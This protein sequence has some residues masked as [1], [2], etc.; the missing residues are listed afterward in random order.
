MPVESGPS[1]EEEI[2]DQDVEAEGDPEAEDDSE[3]IDTSKPCVTG[4]AQQRNGSVKQRLGLL[5]ASVVP[6]VMIYLMLST[7]ADR[8]WSGPTR[9]ELP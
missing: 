8:V 3:L 4:E 6:P 2:L 7:S 1:Q 9:A 5:S